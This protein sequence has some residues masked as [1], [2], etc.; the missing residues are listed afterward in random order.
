MIDLKTYWD[1]ARLF[2]YKW[3]TGVLIALLEHPRRFSQVRQDVQAHSDE[4]LDD[5]ALLRSLK[6]L[7]RAHMLSKEKTRSGRRVVSLYSIT[8]QGRHH[9]DRYDV[10]VASWRMDKRP[11]APCQGCCLHSGM[12]RRHRPEHRSTCR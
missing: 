6:R 4:H 8:P 1:I 9:L 11:A 7:R 3:D 2:R 12:R 5:N 10:L